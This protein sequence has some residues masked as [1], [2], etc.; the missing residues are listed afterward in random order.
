MDLDLAQVRA[1]VAVVDHQHF[2]RAASSLSL[3]QQA[4]SKR[5][6]RLEAQVGLLLERRRGGI[7]L[8]AAGERLLP[9]ARQPYGH[10][11]RGTVVDCLRVQLDPAFDQAGQGPAMATWWMNAGLLHCP[12]RRLDLQ[13]RRA[14][15]SVQLRARLVQGVR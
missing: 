14:G 3:S 7:G 2:G 13:K 15:G 6:A 8:T 10:D 11:P 4:L 5:V 1:F 12:V 9:S